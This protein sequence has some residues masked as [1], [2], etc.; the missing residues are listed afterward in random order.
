M[1]YGHQIDAVQSILNSMT[2]ANGFQPVS[3]GHML[4]FEIQTDKFV[5]I[6]HCHLGHWLTVSTIGAQNPTEVFVYDSLYPCASTVKRQIT[7]LLTTPSNKITLNYVDVQMQSGT[8][9][10]L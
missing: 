5:Q 4:M 9:C 6:L 10:L 3:L 7:S 1:A 2:S 8:C